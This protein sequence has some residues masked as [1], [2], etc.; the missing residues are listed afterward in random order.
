MKSARLRNTMDAGNGN[1][2]TILNIRVT[3]NGKKNEIIE[4]MP[5]GLIKIRL[6]APPVEDKANDLLLKFLASLLCIPKSH[7]GIVSGQRARLKR[8]SIYGMDILTLQN[9]LMDNL[10][11]STR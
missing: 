9:K 6:V 7:I 5:D 8:I 3:P 10:R 11:A 1:N 2:T 4:I